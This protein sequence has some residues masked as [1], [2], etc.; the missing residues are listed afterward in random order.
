MDN[1]LRFFLASQLHKSRLSRTHTP[2]VLSFVLLV[3]SQIVALSP[4]ANAQG[5]PTQW[6]LPPIP[7][8]ATVYPDLSYV[9]HGSPNQRLDLLCT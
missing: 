8:G 3:L 7:L 2:S 4:I 9:S 1:R 5:K 6:P